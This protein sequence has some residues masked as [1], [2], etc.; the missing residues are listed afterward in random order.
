[1]E[2][3]RDAREGQTQIVKHQ[4]RQEDATERCGGPSHRFDARC[5][6][7]GFRERR[8]ARYADHAALVFRRALAAEKAFAGWTLDRR[9][10]QGVIEAT[11]VE[12]GHLRRRS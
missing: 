11:L 8:Y 9:F 5:F 10:A 3:R 4:P 6:V 1:M 2:F 7:F 12:K